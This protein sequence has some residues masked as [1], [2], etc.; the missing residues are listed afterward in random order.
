MGRVYLHVP[1]EERC[2][3]QRLGARWDEQS[4]CWFID[5]SQGDTFRKWL[6]TSEPTFDI[7]SNE[8]FVASTNV[9]C[10]RCHATIPVVCVYC[11]SG[12]IHG[13]PYGPFVVS[14]ITAIDARLR[15]AL[16]KWPSFK[17]AADWDRGECYFV[18]HCP[19]CEAVQRDYF[20]HCEP[21]GAFFLVKGAQ[22][23]AIRLTPI[24]G[25]VSLN[26]DE[27]FEP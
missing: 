7:S 17:Y 1:F 18:N 6:D 9:P 16:E 14:D 22:G 10:W 2:E 8:A 25:R 15:V 20:L 13:E 5:T 4:K 3:V 21:G 24:A 11:E 12:E 19:A 27:G 23:R 26:G